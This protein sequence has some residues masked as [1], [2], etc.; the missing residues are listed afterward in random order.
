MQSRILHSP[1]ISPEPHLTRQY[2]RRI[3]TNWLR[4]MPREAGECSFN[5]VL[6]P[7]NAYLTSLSAPL[8]CIFDLAENRNC[9]TRFNNLPV[10]I[11][12]TFRS[13]KWRKMFVI[14]GALDRRNASLS[15][16]E[17][18]NHSFFL[19]TNPPSYIFIA[20]FPNRAR[21]LFATPVRGGKNLIIP[22]RFL[23]NLLDYRLLSPL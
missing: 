17:L 19:F 21:S 6:V 2:L 3:Y 4:E 23:R 7:Q 20:S 12:S 1:A 15:V 18:H 16:A 14:C 22:P 8:R 13:T 10:Y 11:F 9:Y 5:E